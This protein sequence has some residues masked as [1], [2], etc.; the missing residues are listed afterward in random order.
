MRG[1]RTSQPD[2]LELL[3]DTICNTFGGVLFIAILVIIL[4]QLTGKTRRPEP[5]EAGSPEAVRLLGDKIARLR[6]EIATLRQVRSTQELLEDQLAS[7]DN[8]TLAETRTQI[9]ATRDALATERDQ[10][11]LDIVR[12]EAQRREH[13][14]AAAALMRQVA[15][16]AHDLEDIRARAQKERAT[17]TREARMPTVHE[18]HKRPVPA[19]IRYGRLY[20]WHRYER[21]GERVGLNTEEFVILGEDADGVLTSPKPTAGIPLTAGDSLADTIAERL[22]GFDSEHAYIDAAV[23]PDSFAH[24]QYLRNALVKLGYEYRLL[25]LQ[26]ETTLL[27][28][29][30]T[31][32]GVQ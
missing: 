32:K 5:Q 27:D 17:R 3:L 21:S 4:T 8:K 31:Q 25:P 1:H 22:R 16:A 14:N 13:R 6:A 2:S 15:A 12:R 30:G 9:R 7:T 18:T 20:I 28:R 29:G 19:V 10:L 26:E 24:F 23:R 11:L